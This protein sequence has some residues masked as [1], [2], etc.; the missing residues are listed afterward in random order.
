MPKNLLPLSLL[1]FVGFV[2]CSAEPEKKSEEDLNSTLEQ[3]TEDIAG[4]VWEMKSDGQ[5]FEM[6]IPFQ[7][8]QMDELN[9]I[10]SL[11]YGY[12]ESLGGEVKENYVIVIPHLR[13]ELEAETPDFHY[14]VENYSAL[15]ITTL[16]QDKSSY[17]IINDVAQEEINGMPAMVHEIEASI[18]VSDSLS[19]DAYYMLGVYEGVDAFYQVL[20]WTVQSQKDDF[21]SDMRH[22]IYSFRELGDHDIVHDHGQEDSDGHEGHNH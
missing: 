13:S 11:E 14:N 22:M 9:P 16:M 5:L 15:S 7:M 6:E 21:R 17:E 4:P 12:T 2:S 18:Q 8:E 19:V 3:L 1:F 20:L 10:A